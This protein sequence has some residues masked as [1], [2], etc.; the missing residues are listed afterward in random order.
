MVL[1]KV[2]N[3]NL[4]M[5]NEILNKRRKIKKTRL[6]TKGSFNIFEANTLRSQKGIVK[7]GESNMCEKDDRTKG[8]ELH[9]RCC[10]NCKQPGHNT[11]TCQTDSLVSKD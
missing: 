1:L 9:V 10:S 6:R 8:D 4:R 11:R 5:V 3:K 2:E 7:T